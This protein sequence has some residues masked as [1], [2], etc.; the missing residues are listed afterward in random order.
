MPTIASIIL[1]ILSFYSLSNCLKTAPI[2]VA[3]V[4]G[5][6]WESCL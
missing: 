6:H 5:Q 2:G 4:I 1:Y 3:Y